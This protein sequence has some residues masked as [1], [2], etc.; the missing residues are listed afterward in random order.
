MGWTAAAANTL[1]E[2]RFAPDG[3]RAFTYMKTTSWY[4]TGSDG[5]LKTVETP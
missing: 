3:H 2:S 4:P 5:I 1:W